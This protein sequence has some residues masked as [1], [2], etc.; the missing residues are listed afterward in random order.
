MIH[1]DTELKLAHE[2]M[3]YG[4]FAKNL[5]PK[6]TITWVLDVL[7]FVLTPD[8]ITG[9]LPQQI[10]FIEKYAYIDNKGR[11]ILSWD[12]G[13][14]CN[15][16]CKPTTVPIGSI[17]DIAV[18]DIQIGEEITCDYGTCNIRRNLL[19]QCKVEGCRGIVRSIDLMALIKDIDS[20]VANLIPLVNTVPQPLLRFMIDEHLKRLQSIVSGEVPIPSCI[21]NAYDDCREPKGS[22]SDCD[23][24]S[25]LWTISL[26]TT[27]SA[28]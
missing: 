8:M 15:H 9:L 11:Y 7:D 6:G 4:I 21:E 28:R 10:Q 19:C 22:D 12:I 3:G 24:Q 25:G 2:D 13:K 14:Y 20:E 17:C 16:S 1:P 26:E 27:P 23:D 18:R 5:I